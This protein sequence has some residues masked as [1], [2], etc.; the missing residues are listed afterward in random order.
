MKMRMLFTAFA[1]ICA[2]LVSA[3]TMFTALPV[4]K[5]VRTGK[6]DNGLTYYIRYNKYPEKQADFYIAQKVG[7]I[8]EEEEQ[9]LSHHLKECVHLPSRF[10]IKL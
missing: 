10:P 9:L 8:Q 3:Q 6:L 4:D 1:L 5:D 2:G 7:S